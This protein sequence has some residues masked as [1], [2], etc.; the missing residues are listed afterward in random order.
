MEEKVFYITTPIYYV[1]DV[2]HIGNAYTTMVADIV[3]RFQRL[4]G[5]EVLFATGTD[6]HAIKVAEAAEAEG[7]DPKTFVDRIAPKFKE[8]WKELEISYDDFIRTPEPRHVRVVQEAFRRLRDSGDIY[9]GV[10]EGWYCV[11]DETFFRESEVTDGLCPNPE[12]RRPVQWVQEET[13]YFRLSAYQDRLL[14]WI[15]SNPGCLQPEFRKNEVV[16]F[17]KHGLQDIS[18][19]RANRGWGI[20]VPDEPDKVIYVWFD[21]LLNYITVA[22][23][24]SDEEK[25]HR[26]WPADLQLMGK[27]IFV[28]FHSTFWPAMLMGL[29]IQPPRVLFGHGFWSVEGEKIS[30]SRGN[31]ISPAKLAEDLASRSG[32]KRE[33]AV[34]AIRYFMVREVPFGVDADFS[35]SALVHRFNSDLANDLGNLLN[36]TLSMVGSYFDGVVPKPAGV[37]EE[38]K[39]EVLSAVAECETA[40]SSLEFARG[41][42]AI[43]RAV[44]AGNRFVDERAPWRLMKEGKREEAATVLYSVLETARIVAITLSPVMPSAAREIWRQIGSPGDFESVGWAAAL[45]W[46]VLPSGIMTAGPQ[47]IF[48]R[49]EERKREPKAEAGAESPVGAGFA[50]PPQQ[51][52]EETKPEAEEPV[53]SYDEFKKLDIRV[54]EIKSAEQV[55]GTDKLL[56]LTVDPGDGERTIVAGIAQWYE[57]EKLLGKKIVLLANLQPAKIRGVESRG[58]L[59]AADVDGRAIILTPDE[60]VPSGAKVR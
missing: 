8:V 33:V 13:Y 7:I 47:P 60:D 5:R 49:I 56:Q 57:P 11:P 36:R 35:R 17:I 46:G 1:N 25:F 37:A 30:K 43:W 12:C 53:I 4:L 44:S 48:P 9:R 16:S 40:L 26:T 20:P 6:E 32:A 28:R 2:P 14:Q 21:A 45:E 51:A 19:S 22:G 27:D 55:A 54:A 41:L 3:A 38:I 15:E 23:W 52:P 50:I 59:L 34:D 18:V 10:Y 29:G 42:E 31:A 24:L 39:S 58:M